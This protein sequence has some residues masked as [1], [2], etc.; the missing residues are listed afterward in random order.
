MNQILILF[1]AFSLVLFSLFMFYLL[2][3]SIQINNNISTDKNKQLI[4]K[5]I[6]EG[7]TS[8]DNKDNLPTHKLDPRIYY[9]SNNYDVVYHDSISDLSAQGGLKSTNINFYNV[10]D[11]SGKLVSITYYGNNNPTLPIYNTPGSFMYGKKTYVPTYADSVYLSKTTGGISTIGK[12]TYI[13][14]YA[15]T[16]YLSKTTGEISNRKL[17][18]DYSST[19][20]FCKEYNYSNIE[21]EQHCSQ[22]SKEE[23]STSPCCILLGGSKC[24]AGN[25]NGRY[26]IDNYTNPYIGDK[27]NYYYLVIFKVTAK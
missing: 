6:K 22:L 20:G 12:E 19:G 25:E 24:V 21:L 7:Y 8:I 16:V 3:Q 14:N 13:P 1:F 10:I 15:D 17:S 11:S 26:R 9:N 2:E 18:P 4:L 27:N 23:C 5:N